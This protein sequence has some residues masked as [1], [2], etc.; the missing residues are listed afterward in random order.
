MVFPCVSHNFSY[1]KGIMKTVANS[2]VFC[3]VYSDNNASMALFKL[4]NRHYVRE[5]DVV[6]DECLM[7]A[8]P[9]VVH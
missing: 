3:V 6:C 2:N 8:V 9:K 7:N 1:I 5:R 4:Q